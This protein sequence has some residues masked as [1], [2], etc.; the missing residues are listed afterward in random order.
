MY[1]SYIYIYIYCTPLCLVSQV[2]RVFHGFPSGTVR[3]FGLRG[4]HSCDKPAPWV[5]WTAR[6][7]ALSQRKDI[8]PS[9]EARDLARWALASLRNGRPVPLR[10]RSASQRSNLC[11]EMSTESFWWSLD[12]MHNMSYFECLFGST[13][14]VLAKLTNLHIQV[15]TGLVFSPTL[16]YCIPLLISGWCVY[17]HTDQVVVIPEI[18]KLTRFCPWQDHL[19]DLEE[20]EEASFVAEEWCQF[21]TSCPQPFSS[22]ISAVFTIWIWGNM[23][24]K[25]ATCKLKVRDRTTNSA[26]THPY[27]ID[28]CLSHKSWVQT[29]TRTHSGTIHRI[30]S[31]AD[32]TGSTSRLL[33]RSPGNA[34]R[35][36]TER[37]WHLPGISEAFSQ[38]RDLSGH[39]AGILDERSASN[40]E[41]E[42]N[43]DLVW[44]TWW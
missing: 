19:F 18:M 14:I 43:Q 6:C 26:H 33:N 30:V 29:H 23:R 39:T 31:D 20:E 15:A 44:R 5:R 16:V 1:Y 2:W 9:G 21:M 11:W 36:A 12:R 40:P 38:V 4:T 13:S 22:K 28:S 41:N 24:Q 17:L 34:S 10:I 35:T 3:M 27:P 32:H 7:Q 42:S 25:E 37:Q 8:H